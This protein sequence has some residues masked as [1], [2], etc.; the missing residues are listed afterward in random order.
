LSARIA[1]AAVSARDA[2]LE[3]GDGLGVVA[4]LGQGDPMDRRV[5]LAVAG[6][7]EA[8]AFTV[9]GPDWEWYFP[10]LHS[11]FIKTAKSLGH[12][13]VV[14]HWIFGSGI[15]VEETPAQWTRYTLHTRLKV[16]RHGV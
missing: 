10:L 2:A 8:V 1:S 11:Q 9:P 4:G 15:W 14:R 5:E 3:E 6:A 12:A 13:F 16:V 7:A